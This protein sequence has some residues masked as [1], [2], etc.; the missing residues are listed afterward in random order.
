MR[1]LSRMA[2]LWE[3]DSAAIANGLCESGRSEDELK[4]EGKITSDLTWELKN[5]VNLLYVFHSIEAGCHARKTRKDD[6]STT[7][8]VH[9]G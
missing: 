9:Q 6:S 7:N 4:A 1:L 8:K 3:S 5:G 2:D